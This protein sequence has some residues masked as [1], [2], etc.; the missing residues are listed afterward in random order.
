[1]NAVVESARI[2]VSEAED[3]G[4]PLED[5]RAVVGREPILVPV[6]KTDEDRIETLAD[7]AAEAAGMAQTNV[8]ILHVFTPS[9][10]ERV[11]DRL[12]YGTGTRPDPDHVVKRIGVV[13]ELARELHTPRG[14]WGMTVTVTGRVG[15]AVSDEIVDTAEET[16]AKRVVVGGRRRTPTGKTVF[17]STAQEVLLTAHCPVTFVKDS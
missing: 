12:N 10:F 2:D 16:D 8:H 3:V 1:V 4:V 6:G 14:D 13:R 5:T 7:A 15:E 17:G 11:V 9:R